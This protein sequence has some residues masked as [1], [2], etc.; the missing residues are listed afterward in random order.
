MIH[1]DWLITMIR[2]MTYNWSSLYGV[3]N[4]MFKDAHQLL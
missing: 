1:F 4:F 2:G 3:Y